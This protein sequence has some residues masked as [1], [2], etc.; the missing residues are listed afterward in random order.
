MAAAT[1]AAAAALRPHTTLLSGGSG[2]IPSTTLQVLPFLST[3]TFRR[4]RSVLVSNASSSPS[5]PPTPEKEAVAEAVPVP[6]AESCVNLGLELFSK[7]RVRDALEQFENALELNPTPIEAQ[8]ALYNKA[9]CH[10]YRE[11]SKKAAEC[12]RT[13]LRDYNLKFGTILNDPDLAPFRASPEF[14]ELQ[15]EALRGGEDIGSGFRRDLKLISEVQAPFRGVRRFFYVALTAAAGISTFF[16]IPRL[17]L[18]VQGGDGAPD[19]LETAGNAAINIGGIVV[20]VALYF[21]E[22]KKEEKQITQISRNETLSRLPVRLSTNRIIELVQLRDITRP[23]ILAGSKASVTQALQR[24]ERYRTELLKRGVLLIP[25]IFGAS[26]KDQTK[27]R[28]FGTRRAAASAPSVGGDFEKRT[29]SIAA[30]S[31]LKAEVRF[32]ADV[33][34]PEQWESWIRDQQESEGVTPGEDVYIILR[35]DGRVRR[36][37]IGMPNWNDILQELPRLEDLMSKLER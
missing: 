28:G 23:V 1:A 16:T 13:A 11:E 12:L 34:S 27:P 14:K 31:C 18:A 15:E 37:G 33:V 36:S 8:A 22:N 25:V 24:A 2:P 32:K 35:L 3:L 9:C 26:K 17:I 19:L 20:L 21:W 30:K 7:G 10:A 5:S 29:E 4:G 6:T